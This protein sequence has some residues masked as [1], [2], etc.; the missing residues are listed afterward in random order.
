MKQAVIDCI[1]GKVEVLST[2]TA[3]KDYYYK[4]N[5]YEVRPIA[6]EVMIFSGPY[7]DT[8]ASKGFRGFIIYVYLDK[9]ERV[10]HIFVGGT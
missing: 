2:K 10:E 5:Q 7:V 6:H 9:H 4:G 8:P 1:G 3:P